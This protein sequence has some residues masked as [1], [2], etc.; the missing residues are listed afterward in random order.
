MLMFSFHFTGPL[1]CLHPP[2][3]FE[4]Q[5]LPATVRATLDSGALIARFDSPGGFIAAG[6]RDGSVLLWDLAT[7]AVIRHFEGH[8]KAITGLG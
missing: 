6:L 7:Q 2:H 4:V 1:C 8:V 3:P 5:N